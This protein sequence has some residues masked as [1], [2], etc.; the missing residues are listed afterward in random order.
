[1]TIILIKIRKRRYKKIKKIPNLES[2]YDKLIMNIMNKILPVLFFVTCSGILFGQIRDADKARKPVDNPNGLNSS[3][4]PREELRVVNPR[5][6]IERQKMIE[7]VEEGEKEFLKFAE[8][9]GKTSP[10]ETL[11]LNR[12][13]IAKEN[14]R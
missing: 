5:Q 11:V 10:F 12:Y 6:A 4:V 3:R 2:V 14:I 9:D 7:Q 8:S 1:M 13:K